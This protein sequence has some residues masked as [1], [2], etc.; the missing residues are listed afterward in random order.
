M[1]GT[2]FDRL[3]T[4]RSAKRPAT[5]VT[6]LTDGAQALVEG[7]AVSGELTLAAALLAEVRGRE[8]ADRSGPLDTDSSLFVRIYAPPPRL[9]AVGAVHIAQALAPMA[10]LVGYEVTIIDPRRSFAARDRFPNVSL[11]DEWPDEALARLAPDARTAVVTLTH[12]PKFD[13]P[14]LVAA[15][16]SPAFYVGAL[17]SSRTH[18]QR[19]ERLTEMGMKHQLHRL[20]APVGLDLGGRS[21]AEIALAILAQITQV[22]YA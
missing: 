21:P 4:A 14:A 22:R 7:G 18:S 13:D 20:H 1:N 2:L 11:T 10:T 12:D 5:V 16:E 17:G 9:L 3:Y 8:R 6:R 15:L 19:I